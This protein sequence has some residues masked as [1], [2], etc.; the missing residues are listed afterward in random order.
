[1]SDNLNED[2]FNELNYRVKIE[3]RIHL[4]NRSIKMIFKKILLEEHRGKT[5]RNLK[6]ESDM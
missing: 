2:V 1:M 5:N 6:R 4:E 3:Q